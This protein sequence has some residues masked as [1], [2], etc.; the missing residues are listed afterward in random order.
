MKTVITPARPTDVTAAQKD[1]QRMRTAL[2][3]F[4]HASDGNLT[5][6]PDMRTSSW[7]PN[8]GD[9]LVCAAILREVPLAET[10]RALS[11][12]G[13]GAAKKAFWKCWDALHLC[14]RK[15]GAALLI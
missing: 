13:R 7:K 6:W 11:A 5:T 10:V 2:V 9:M 15:T 14:C 3:H 8:Y 4:N 12:Y 1:W